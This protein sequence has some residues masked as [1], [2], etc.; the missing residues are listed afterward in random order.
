MPSPNLSLH[1]P[2]QIV[3]TP[4]A[5][6]PSKFEYP[7]PAP[8]SEGSPSIPAQNNNNLSLEFPVPTTFP[9]PNSR[10]SPTH[11]KLRAVA[12]NPPVPPGLVKKKHRWSFGLLTR[13]KSSKSS[14]ETSPVTEEPLVEEGT[15]NPPVQ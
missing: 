13:R 6:G 8:N 5:L 3:G 10:Y 15:A 12:S 2:T 9:P 14:A 7:F 11:P 4:F 1:S